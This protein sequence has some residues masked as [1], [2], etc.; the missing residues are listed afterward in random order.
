[1]LESGLDVID[2]YPI[3][4][5]AKAGDQPPSFLFQRYDTHWATT[6]LLASL[7][8]IAARITQY[9]WYEKA[10]PTPGF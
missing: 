6:G 2:L 3:L 1:M 9:A 10:G 7:E 5:A 4:K 8:A